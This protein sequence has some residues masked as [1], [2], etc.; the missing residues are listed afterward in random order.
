MVHLLAPHRSPS[1]PASM[2][3]TL[4]FFPNFLHSSRK[5]SVVIEP[6]KPLPTTTRSYGFATACVRFE[7]R[8]AMMNMFLAVWYVQK[9]AFGEQLLANHCVEQPEQGYITVLKPLRSHLLSRYSP[10]NHPAGPSN[11]ICLLSGAVRRR[12]ASPSSPHT[13]GPGQHT[14][15]RSLPRRKLLRIAPLSVVDV[16]SRRVDESN[17]AAYSLCVA[18]MVFPRR[19]FVSVANGECPTGLGNTDS[20]CAHCS[21]FE[22]HDDRVSGRHRINNTEAFSMLTRCL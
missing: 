1:F 14:N 9:C 17:P 7:M 13:S 6:A 18:R 22:I 3:Q 11:S 4:P 12:A 5:F 21:T 8:E 10:R 19:I 15:T 2:R 20:S 16:K